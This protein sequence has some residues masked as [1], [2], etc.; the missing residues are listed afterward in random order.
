MEDK[1]AEYEEAFNILATDLIILARKAKQVAQNESALFS[2][3]MAKDVAELIYMCEH[4]EL[5][6]TKKNGK[7]QK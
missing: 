4:V 6:W 1:A 7:D 5:K 2:G 3:Y